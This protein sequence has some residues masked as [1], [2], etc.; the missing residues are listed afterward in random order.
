MDFFANIW[1]NDLYRKLI[2]TV[3][4]TV[5]VL[6][7]RGIVQRY[8]LSRYHG[9]PHQVYMLGKIVDYTITAVGLILLFGLWIQQSADLT[10][11]VGLVAAGLAFALQEVIGSIAG[12][13]SIIFGRPFTLGDRIET[14]GIHGDVVDISVLRTTLMETGSWLGGMQSTGRIVTLSN[15]FIF[16][17][18][19][20]NYSRDLTVVWDEVR[21]S[22]PYGEDWERAKELMVSII[23]SNPEYKSL[24]PTARV[25]QAEIQRRLAVTMSPLEPRA[26]TK[27]ADSW[28]ELGVVYPVAYNRR[29]SFRS[30]VTE[31]ILRT[32]A[33]EGIP[34]AFPTMTIET[35]SPTKPDDSN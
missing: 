30:V 27:M 6:I 8:I 22:V 4:I 7:L 21:V 31:G 26:Y 32:F 14:G 29:R 3:I 15:A 13:L 1:A 18:P 5:G 12:W 9:D 24:L 16:K 11:A 35:T 19:L 25:Q 33:A 28:I 17:E 34:I 10:V 23:T 20:F 2:L